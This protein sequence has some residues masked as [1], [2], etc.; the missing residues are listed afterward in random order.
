MKNLITWIKNEWTLLTSTEIPVEVTRQGKVIV[1]GAF[2]G[3]NSAML[4]G[5]NR[6]GPGIIWSRSCK[7]LLVRIFPHTK[8]PELLSYKGSVLD[9]DPDT[10]KVVPV[11]P[12]SLQL[13]PG[14]NSRC[15]DPYRDTLTTELSFPTMKGW[16]IGHAQVLG[17]ETTSISVLFRRREQ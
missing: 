12:P 7:T 5:R 16:D 2:L 4:V 6:T 3:G 8:Q 11:A 15:L 17:G 9:L 13:Q 10:M 1:F 14:A